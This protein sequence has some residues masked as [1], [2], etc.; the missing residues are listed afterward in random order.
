M[1]TVLVTGSNRGIGFE[2]TKQY[3]QD[4]CRVIALCRAPQSATELSALDGNLC[5]EKCEITNFNDV[6]RVA[7]KLKDEK[8]DIL[9]NNAGMF[10]PKPHR[11]GDLRQNFGHMDYDLWEQ[12]NRINTL[13]PMKIAESFIDNVRSSDQKKIINITAILASITNTAA[14]FYAYRSSKTA[15]HMI[16]ASLAKELEGEGITV[17]MLNPGWVKTDMGG[18]EAPLTPEQ[19]ITA[20]RK[21][22][23]EKTIGD[24]GKFYEYD[25]TAI[26][27]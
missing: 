5:I 21:L 15:V 17:L 25:G 2:L 16:M 19:S 9:I 23:A 20:V 4:G 10:G 24:T 1:T 27:W 14:N 7:A 11:D 3:V 13:T 12:I 8:I 26:P 18:D 22:I 6:D